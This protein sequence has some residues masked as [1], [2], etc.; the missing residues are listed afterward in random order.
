VRPTST[1]QGFLG[2]A[3]SLST[4]PALAGAPTDPDTPFINLVKSL[5]PGA[6]PLLR[7]GGNSGDSAWWPIPS[8]Q[9]RQRFLY[10]LTPQWA[11]RVHA[12]LEALG[13]KTILGVNLKEGPKIVARIAP[14]EVAD[15]DRYVGAGLIDAFEL[16]NEP[17]STRCRSCRAGR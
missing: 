3:T 12:L 10:P 4:I 13:G 11:A 8:M 2:L 7:L 15:F 9:K 1:T 17:S 5:S 6:P 14:L 16:G